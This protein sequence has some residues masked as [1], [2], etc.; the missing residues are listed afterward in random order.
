MSFYRV[1]KVKASR[2]PRRC[3]WCGEWCRKGEPKVATALVYDGD[4]CAANWHPECH[5]VSEEWAR[6]E[7]ANAGVELPDRRSMKRGSTE[8][9]E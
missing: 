3:Y 5:K 1:T 8:E 9:K 4:F 7:Y 6:E 2:K